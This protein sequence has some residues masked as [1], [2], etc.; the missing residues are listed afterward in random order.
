[1]APTLILSTMIAIGH[2]ITI[3]PIREKITIH[4]MALT[5]TE[6][7]DMRYKKGRV[8]SVG[9]EIGFLEDGDEIYYDKTRSFTLVV[10]NKE[11]TVIRGVDVVLKA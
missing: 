7:E 4:G 11:V 2:Y 5:D 9:H 3:E 1:M 8:L 6:I 10:D